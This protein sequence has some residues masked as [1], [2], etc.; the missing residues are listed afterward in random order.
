[1]VLVE[2]ICLHLLFPLYIVATAASLYDFI[3]IDVS[4]NLLAV[5]I[6]GCFSFLLVFFVWSRC[7]FRS[8]VKVCLGSS[9]C[10]DL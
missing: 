9:F 1:M 8:F 7:F 4:S 10:S 5:N 6:F 2:Y 3:Y